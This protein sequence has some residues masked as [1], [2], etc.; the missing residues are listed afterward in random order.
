[1]SIIGKSH[2]TCASNFG[3]K[4]TVIPP[5]QTVQYSGHSFRVGRAVDLLMRADHSNKSC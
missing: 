3:G 2:P 5:L 4:V 1:M